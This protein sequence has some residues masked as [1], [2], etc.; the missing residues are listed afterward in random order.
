MWKERDWERGIG[1]EGLGERFGDDRDR[2]EREIERY[3]ERERDWE[4]ERERE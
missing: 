2:D 3:R 4:K 1:R